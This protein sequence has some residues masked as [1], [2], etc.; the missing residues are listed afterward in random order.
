MTYVDTV[1]L[2]GDADGEY[3]ERKPDAAGDRVDCARTTAS[4][5]TPPGPTGWPATCSS[6]IDEEIQAT[7]STTATTTR[8]AGG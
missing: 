7:T 6:L 1:P 3:V 2:F 8:R 5:S 4:T